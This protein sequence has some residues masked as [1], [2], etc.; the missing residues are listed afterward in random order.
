MAMGKEELYAKIAEAKANKQQA[1][2]KENELETEI[3]KLII[4]QRG[5]EREKRVWET[6]SV[7]HNAELHQLEEELKTRKW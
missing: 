4:Q 1:D 5:K 6:I 7:A 2:L 3:I